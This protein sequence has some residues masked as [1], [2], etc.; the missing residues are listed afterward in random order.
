MIRPIIFILS[1]FIILFSCKTHYNEIR[2]KD[3]NHIIEEF[4][5]HSSKKV[6]IASHRASNNKYPENSLT[7]VKYAIETGVDIIE[8][9]IRTTKDG[10][11]VLMHNE[12]LNHTTNGKGKVSDYTYEELS[13]LKLDKKQR[14]TIDHK[15]PLAEDALKLAKGKIM[16]DLD[17]KETHV[18]P[19]VDLVHKT[20]TQGQVMFFD[21]NFD[22][23]DSI[24]MLDST[25]IIM[26]RAYSFDDVKKIIE[27]YNPPVIHIDNSFYS[28]EVVKTIKESGARIWINALVFPDLKARLGFVDWGYSPLTDGGANIIQTDLPVKLGMFLKEKG[29]R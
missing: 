4:H 21:S 15:I 24:L 25:L 29:L 18:K 14:D 12:T 28:A 6:L 23:L 16:V 27:K 5:N 1:S 8:I 10:R 26:P 3:F 2:T 9:D 19:L 13:K 22:V 11:L 17:I 7:A 20:Q